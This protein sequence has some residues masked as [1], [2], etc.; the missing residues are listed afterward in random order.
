M[1]G[2]P[3]RGRFYEFYP[4]PI[5]S[6]GALSRLKAAFGSPRHLPVGLPT[7]RP[8]PP[9]PGIM[10]P[11]RHLELESSREQLMLKLRAAAGDRAIL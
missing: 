8:L 11:L 3:R 5:P 4:R 2:S 7:D 9:S 1:L 10:R 6:I